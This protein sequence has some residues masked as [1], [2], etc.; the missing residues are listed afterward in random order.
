MNQWFSQIQVRHLLRRSSDHVPLVIDLEE[1]SQQS[2]KEKRCVF[3]FEEVWTKDDRCEEE[4]HRAWSL[5]HTLIDKKIEEFR[6]LR[7]LFERCP[8]NN[9][10]NKIVRVEDEINEM[11]HWASSSKDLSKM[12]WLNNQLDDLLAS[13]EVIWRQRSLTKWLNRDK[14]TKRFHGKASQRKKNKHYQENQRWGWLY[15]PFV[16]LNW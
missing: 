15:K 9:I 12:K 5:P 6:S 3:R 14:N 16:R 4:I 2:H 10:G 7:A 11:N 13:E 8:R 1:N